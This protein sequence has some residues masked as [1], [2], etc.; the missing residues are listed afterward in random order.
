[1]ASSGEIAEYR[2]KISNRL[3]SQRSSRSRDKTDRSKPN[4]QGGSKRGDPMRQSNQKST[5]SGDVM[6]EDEN[7]L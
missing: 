3:D 4:S 6:S 2:K 5:M 1:M 7:D